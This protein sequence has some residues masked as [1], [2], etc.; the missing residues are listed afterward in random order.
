[1]REIQQDFWL[2]GS[3]LYLPVPPRLNKLLN[4]NI[5]EKAHSICSNDNE[6]DPYN[7]RNWLLMGMFTSTW[8]MISWFFSVH[9][10]LHCIQIQNLCLPISNKKKPWD[11]LTV[12]TFQNV[13]KRLNEGRQSLH[14]CPELIVQRGWIILQWRALACS[15]QENKKKKG[16][17]LGSKIGYPMVVFC[18]FFGGIIKYL[19][20]SLFQKKVTKPSLYQGN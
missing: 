7:S 1:M 8:L 2:L 19:T 20:N 5:K 4:A 12:N 13:V 15:L 16:L 17:G 18:L 9:W 10:R 14:L 11:Q 6:N 3:L